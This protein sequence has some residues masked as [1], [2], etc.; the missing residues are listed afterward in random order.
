MKKQ[1]H[2]TFRYPFG[3]DALREKLKAIRA[4][5]ALGD[6]EYIIDLKNSNRL[7]LGVM[8]AGHSGYWYVADIIEDQGGSVLIKGAIVYDPDENGNAHKM[9]F[10]D[11]LLKI[12]LF[13]L[14]LILEIFGLFS[15]LISKM[16]NK[17]RHLP[18]T[19][20]KLN[21]FMLEY[22]CCEKV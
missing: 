17:P 22:L 1:K 12:V 3:K 5:S 15:A 18:D 16:K 9:S 4:D 19:E 7:F 20:E 13:P 6:G 11:L 14:I 10:T 8:R 2:F 21:K